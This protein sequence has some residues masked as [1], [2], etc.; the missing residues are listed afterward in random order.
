MVVYHGTTYRRAERICQEGFKP[1]K[2]SR[3]V[4]FA[5]ARSY[6]LGRAKC[7]A[8]RAHDRP[9]VLTCDLNLG[10]VRSRVGPKK[11]FHRN[12]VIAISSPVPVSVLRSFP[13]AVDQPSTPQELAA[14]VNQILGVKSY[15]GVSP[16]DPGIDRL[17]RW[18]ASRL[19]TTV[20]ARINPTELLS[21]A[22]QWLP[23]YFR[24]VVVD[25]ERLQAFRRV[26]TIDLEIRESDIGESKDETQA[27]E[28]LED[29]KP[30][31]RARGLSLLAKIEDPDLFEW[32]V[33]SLDDE[34]TE[35]RIA[36]LRAMRS[37]EDSDPEV[38]APFARS[39]DKRVRGA[40]IAAL[41]RHSNESATYW[42]RRGLRD[43]EPCVRVETASVLP[44]LDPAGNHSI[45]ETALYDPN[46]DIRRRA[47]ELTRGKGYSKAR[48]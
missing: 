21:L 36:A 13:A 44:E 47:E 43:P 35:V 32:C 38:I 46:P 2:P 1:R 31:R 20:G 27:L 19:S 42:F 3:R 25:R 45:F 16:R 28:F 6:A 33:M 18:V 30:A 34:S 14:W 26:K 8:K 29:P 41:A 37:C 15:K 39:E 11:V 9:V 4:W 40:A 5:E 12:G 7:Q 48:C 24:G 23:E 22:Q 10:Q 17:S